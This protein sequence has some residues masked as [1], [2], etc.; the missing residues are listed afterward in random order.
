[1]KRIIVAGVALLFLAL[2]GDGCSDGSGD[3]SA[4]STAKWGSAKWGEG[5][6]NE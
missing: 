1:M 4:D 3:D 2:A 6:W 5:K